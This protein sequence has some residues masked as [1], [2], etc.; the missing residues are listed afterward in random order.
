MIKFIRKLLRLCEHKYKKVSWREVSING[1]RCSMR[2]YKCEI[3][4]QEIEVD[5]RFDKN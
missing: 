5:G 2:T 4:G 1:Y 3:C